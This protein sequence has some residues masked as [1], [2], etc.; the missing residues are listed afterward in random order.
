MHTQSKFSQSIVRVVLATAILLLIPL[1]AMQYSDEWNWSFFDFIFMG[2]LLLGTGFAYA[3]AARKAGILAHRVAIGVGLAAVFL[4]V[5]VNAA[6]GIIGDGPVNLM[7][8]GVP[9]VL[10]IGAFIVRFKPRGMVL[11]LFAAALT[12]MLVPVIALLVWN[13]PFNPGIIQVFGLNA[14]FA[15][16]FIL[17]ALLFRNAAQKQA[18]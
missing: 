15:I 6:V 2:F 14:F 5:W 4:L 11:V 3:L 17:S 16:L 18:G 9:A 13:A 10:I 8:I 12:Q 7:Y 1:A